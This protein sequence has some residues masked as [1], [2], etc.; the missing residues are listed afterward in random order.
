MKRKVTLVVV[1]Y[2]VGCAW[3]WLAAGGCCDETADAVLYA[4]VERG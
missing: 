3:L 1:L 4:F 2:A